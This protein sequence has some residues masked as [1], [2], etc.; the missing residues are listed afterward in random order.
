MRCLTPSGSRGDVD[1]ADDRRAGRS[2]S[3]ARTACGWSST[4]RRRCCRESRRS[5]RAATS[6]DTSS[7]ATNCAEAARQVAGRRSR[8]PSRLAHGIARSAPERPLQPRLG[9]PD[10]RRARACDRARPAAR[11]ICASSTSVLVATPA[12]KRSPTT[13]LRLGRRR[14]RRR[15]RRRSPARLDSS[16]SR[17][18]AH[19]EGDLPIELGDARVR[20]AVALAAA[21]ALL[22][23]DAAAVPQR[24]R[25]R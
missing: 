16:S 13:R 17:R 4:C 2:A 15:P 18:C 10:A 22:G 19:F 8:W 5:R 7:T 21:S 20:G 24:P 14:A 3:A 9:E 1:A 23:A 12:V 25:Q 6:N 11:A